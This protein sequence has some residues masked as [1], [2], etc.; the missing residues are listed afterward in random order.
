MVTPAAPRSR[1]TSAAVTSMLVRVSPRF[2]RAAST[3]VDTIAV[4]LD[5]GSLCSGRVTKLRGA[6]AQVSPAERDATQWLA[7]LVGNLTSEPVA[8]NVELDNPHRYLLTHRPE[9]P[10]HDYAQKHTTYRF[11]KQI[12]ARILGLRRVATV[13]PATRPS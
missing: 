7:A 5:A 4:P 2:L 13:R 8:R 11:A 12:G 10:T 1:I 3:A 9:G 6:P